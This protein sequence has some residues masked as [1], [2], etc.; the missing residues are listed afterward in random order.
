MDKKLTSLNAYIQQAIRENWEGL[1]LTDFNGTSLQY[2]AVARKIAKL[3][4]LFETPAYDTATKSPS[5]DATVAS[6]PRPSWLH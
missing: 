3:H 4:I 1:A 6:G 2:R 5:A